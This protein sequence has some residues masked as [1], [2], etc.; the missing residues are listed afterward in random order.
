MTDE[1]Y[2]DLV[3]PDVPDGRAKAVFDDIR[4]TR[5]DELDDRLQVNALWQAYANAPHLLEA[6]WPH[7]RAA[8]RDGA[9]PYELVSKVSLVTASVLTCE[10]CRHFHTSLLRERGVDAAEIER[11]RAAE[12]ADGPFSPRETVILQFAETLAADHDAIGPADLERLRE[13]G[14]GDRAIVELVDAV[15]IHVHTAVVQSALGLVGD[16]QAPEGVPD[17]LTSD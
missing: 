15:A 2:V 7:M 11:L 6:F 16:D 17:E 13:A 9:L 4:A 10:K 14:L 1:P 12:V 8:Y 3:S 5:G